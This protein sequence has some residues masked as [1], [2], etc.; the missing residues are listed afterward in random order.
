M[1]IRQLSQDKAL[2]FFALNL[3]LPID[4]HKIPWC[5]DVLVWN[6]VRKDV[7]DEEEKAGL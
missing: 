2:G 7:R 3:I 1:P 4:A 5:L 6:H